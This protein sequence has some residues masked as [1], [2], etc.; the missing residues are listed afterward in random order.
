MADPLSVAASLTGVLAFTFKITKEVLALI[1]EI[2]DAPDD[3]DDLKLQVKHLPP[4]IESIQTLTVTYRLPPGITGLQETLENY[5]KHCQGVLD[6][7]KVQLGKF[8]SRGSGKKS[9]MRIIGWA[10]RKSEIRNLRDR[11]RESQ[12]MLQTSV[13]AYNSY[14]IGKGTQEITEEVN[15]GFEKIKSQLRDRE[16]FLKFKKRLQDDL[17]SVSASVERR[18]SFS[19]TDAGLPLRMFLN[20]KELPGPVVDQMSSP[21]TSLLPLSPDTPDSAALLLQATQ[22]CNSQQVRTLISMGASPSIRFEDGR[23]ALH[24][25]AI[26]DDVATAEILLDNG[27]DID[28][29][30]NK[31]RSPLRVAINAGSFAIATFLLGKGSS[32]DNLPSLQHIIDLGQGA[33]GFDAFLQAIRERLDG[34][35]QAAL[36]HKFADCHGD[37][38]RQAAL[39]HE[40]IDHYDDADLDLP[41]KA[42]LDVHA[43]DSSGI[44]LIHHAILCSRKSALRILLSYGADANDYIPPEIRSRLRDNVE[45]HQHIRHIDNGI[46]A[47]TT[48]ACVMQSPEMVRMLLK[49]GADPNKDYPGPSPNRA[50]RYMCDTAFLESAKLMI[51]FGADVNHLEPDG[52]SPVYW[53]VVC[54]ND[55][56]VRYMADRG[57]ADFGGKLGTDDWTLLQLAIKNRNLVMARVLVKFGADPKVRDRLKR[58]L[59]KMIEQYWKPEERDKIHSRIFDESEAEEEE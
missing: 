42:G 10:M 20:D 35:R 58:T 27:A 43:R 3:I 48:A 12:A 47:L 19:A 33:V 51:D 31:T 11:L 1:D 46:T 30:D 26:Y 54:N 8:I 50:L 32:V 39:L 17:E 38:E 34:E 15:R 55:E 52:T 49:S 44:S 56:L 2:R 5:L 13:V 14:L 6:A 53:A 28:A 57:R 29:M 40:I 22:A 18:T 9:P 37:A 59:A 25:C 16:T 41:L 4:L 36:L 7:I 24:F 21:D 23:T 45:W